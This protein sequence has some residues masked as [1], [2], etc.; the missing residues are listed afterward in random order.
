MVAL[1]ID[2]SRTTVRNRAWS[3][4]GCSAR[5]TTE[6]PHKFWLLSN[7][8]RSACRNSSSEK[9]PNPRPTHCGFIPQPRSRIPSTSPSPGTLA[10]TPTQKN[11]MNS[12]PNQGGTVQKA[13]MGWGA[14][15]LRLYTAQRPS[16]R[17]LANL[18]VYSDVL[19]GVPATALP[20]RRLSPSVRTHA[21]SK[22]AARRRAPRTRPEGSLFRLGRAASESVAPGDRTPSSPRPTLTWHGPIGTASLLGG[23]RGARRRAAVLLA[24]VRAYR[25]RQPTAWQCGGRHALQSSEYTAGSP[26]RD[27]TD[28]GRCTT[29]T[30]RLPNPS[31]PSGRCRLDWVAS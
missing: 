29:L 17:E 30:G 11:P 4:T 21:R 25:W 20:C 22:T 14:C 6:L 27:T 19:Q 31:T 26:T 28:V 23:V 7:R 24:C 16:Y 2:V 8:F 9:P 12:P 3:A 15:P 10:S 18:R 13:S 5:Y 1:N